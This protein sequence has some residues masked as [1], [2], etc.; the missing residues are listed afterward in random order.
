[1]KIT[2]FEEINFILFLSL[3][4]KIIFFLLTFYIS[5]MNHLESMKYNLYTRVKESEI[6]EA[7]NGRKV[8][9]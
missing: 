4:L 3:F 2:C 7:I 8:T 5:L 1:M 6:E 9:F